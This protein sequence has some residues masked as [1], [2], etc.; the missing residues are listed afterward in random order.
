MS[1]A[2]IAPT[3][4]EAFLAARIEEQKAANDAA[5][6]A[7]AA[8]GESWLV[9]KVENWRRDKLTAAERDTYTTAACLERI[10]TDTLFR[11]HFRKEFTKQNIHENAQIDWIR[12]HGFPDL[13]KPPANR[14][15]TCLHEGTLTTVV[16]RTRHADATKTLDIHSPAAG[17]WGVLKYTTTEGGSQD[18]QFRDVQNFIREMI[19]CLR[20]GR[21][22]G[23][24]F[25]F[26][27]D[28]PYYTDAKRAVLV[29]MTAE[30]AGRI[31]ITSAAALV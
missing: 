13:Y 3:S 11:A 6:V 25:Y 20:A 30:F 19:A 22:E 24:T 8:T 31:R 4:F 9:E 18:N 1:A 21:A 29:G 10:R 16:S 23:L 12:A 26:F 5:A 17:M 7:A 2:A 14:G 15:G 28:G 27:L